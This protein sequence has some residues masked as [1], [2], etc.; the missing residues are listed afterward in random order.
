[1]KNTISIASTN[2]I[3]T[4]SSRDIAES[5]EKEHF[6][7]IRDIETLTGGIS[8]IGDTPNLF[9]ETQYQNEQ[10]KQF[11]KEYLLTRDGFS[12]LVMG[13]TGSK[14]LEWKLRYIDAFNTMEHHIKKEQNEALKD[15]SPQLQVLIRLETEQK[16]LR[17]EFKAATH[18]AIEAEHKVT[19]VRHELQGIRDIIA[20]DTTS[21]RED[22]SRIITKIAQ[23]LGGNEHIRDVRAEAYGLLDKRMGVSLKTRLTNLRGR[24]SLEGVCKSKRD[25]TNHMDVIA[26]DKKLIEGFVA[27]VKEMAIK[28][29]AELLKGA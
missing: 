22:T 24:M 11:Y 21:W 9:I 3:L 2:G 5:F 13:F 6:H 23:K 27:I 1:M 16:L 18:K 28:Y 29:G 8:K 20:L 7:I 15:L 14:S 4:V 12:L 17:Q 10:N 25:K 19:E 26:D